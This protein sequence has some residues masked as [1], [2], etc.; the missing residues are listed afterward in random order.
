MTSLQLFKQSPDLGIW[1]EMAIEIHQTLFQKTLQ[2]TNS[3]GTQ[4]MQ[5]S[6]IRCDAHLFDCMLSH[7]R[8]SV[9]HMD[10]LSSHETKF[11]LN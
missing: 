10:S 2:N 8:F 5:I 6:H 1:I 11:H 7:A 9:S 4:T 3:M